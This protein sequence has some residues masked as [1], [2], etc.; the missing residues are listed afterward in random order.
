MAPNFRRA[1]F[2]L[3]GF[4]Q[5]FTDQSLVTFTELFVIIYKEIIIANTLTNTAISCDNDLS[6]TKRLRR[7]GS[8]NVE[9][10]VR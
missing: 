8:L 3:I 4:P 6:L 1:Q 2:S 5:V 10:M 7:S 9:A